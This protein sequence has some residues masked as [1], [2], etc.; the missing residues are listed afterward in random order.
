MLMIVLKGSEF[1]MIMVFVGDMIS[2]GVDEE[3]LCIIDFDIKFGVI[4]EMYF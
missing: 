4:V 2:F 3:L 1:F